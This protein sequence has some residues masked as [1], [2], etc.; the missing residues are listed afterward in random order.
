MRVGDVVENPVT[1]ERGI[2]IEGTDEIGGERIVAEVHVRPGGAVAGEH[3]HPD[4]EE[5]FDVVRGTVGFRVDGRESTGGPGTSVTIPPGVWHD[6]WNAGEEEAVF[7]VEVSPG[8]RFEQMI[9]TLFGLALDGKTNRKGM[10]RPLQLAVIAHDFDDVI[11]FRKP[12]RAVQKALFGAL[13]PIG[14]IRGYRSIYPRYAE[15][16]SMGTPEQVRSG[17]PLTPRFGDGPGPPR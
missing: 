6:W 10:P 9:R 17:A 5:S 13:A 15:A 7:R 12:P 1:G 2:V 16:A 14:R 4:I 11:Q 8:Q 3:L